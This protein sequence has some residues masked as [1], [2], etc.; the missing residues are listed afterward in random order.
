MVVPLKLDVA[1]SN[2]VR[3]FRLDRAI[4]DS[5]EAGECVHV[6]FNSLAQRHSKIKARVCWLHYV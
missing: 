4:C 5:I 1:W 6:P 2:T 3:L